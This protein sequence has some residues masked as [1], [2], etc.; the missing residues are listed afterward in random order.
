MREKEGSIV[1]VISVGGSST[2]AW[3]WGGQELK[4]VCGNEL[5]NSGESH[6]L[7][8]LVLAAA[9]A[10]AV[11]ATSSHGAAPSEEA[12]LG[13]T[14][15]GLALEPAAQ[16][17]AFVEEDPQSIAIDLIFAHFLQ[18]QVRRVQRDALQQDALQRGALQRDALQQDCNTPCNSAL[19]RDALQQDAGWGATG[20]LDGN[21]TSGKR[22]AASGMRSR[23]GAVPCE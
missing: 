5:G 18:L 3:G 16:A 14:L 7:S 12:G 21:A 17:E 1:C 19:R 13:D 23:R 20:G 11:P 15:A 9:A 6:A 10:M 2:H 4:R 8:L 22:G